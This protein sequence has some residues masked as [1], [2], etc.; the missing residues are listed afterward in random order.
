VS[1]DAAA[2]A[3]AGAWDLPEVEVLIREIHLDTFGHVNNA[4]YLS[5]FEQARWDLIEAGGYGL[6]VIRETGLGP[7]VLEAAIKFMRE[8]GLREH[9]RIQSRAYDPQGGKIM[10]MRQRMVN[11]R[12]E[13]CCEAEF[14]FGLFS[15]RERKLVPPTPAWL[16]AIGAPTP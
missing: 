13:I 15:L 11:S 9:I 16:R 7:V 2:G 8:I 10:R 14:K 5:L 6:R 12:G 1:A 3:E 4:T